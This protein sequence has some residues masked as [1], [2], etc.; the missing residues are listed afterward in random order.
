MGICDLYSVRWSCVV[1][2]EF[3]D[4]I[5]DAVFDWSGQ[6]ANMYESA[7]TTSCEMQV[8]ISRL[9]YYMFHARLGCADRMR[10][11]R[12]MS[13]RRASDRCEKGEL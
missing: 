1:Q 11:Q 10:A 5:G 13:L 6:C 7:W 2:W 3:V 12:I 9:S 8:I 4:F